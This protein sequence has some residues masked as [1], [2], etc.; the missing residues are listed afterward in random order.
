VREQVKDWKKA[1]R[2]NVG[3]WGGKVEGNGENERR[4][5]LVRRMRTRVQGKD[6]PKKS[7]PRIVTGNTRK[8]EDR[9]GGRASWW[10]GG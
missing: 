6:V 5:K 7:L 4:E 3:G 2:R 9:N 1:G 10:G 8:I